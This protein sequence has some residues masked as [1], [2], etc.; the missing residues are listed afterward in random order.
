MREY[1]YCPF[2]RTPMK[3]NAEGILACQD[4]QECGFV[5]YDNPIPVVAV[6][7]PMAHEFLA[8]AGMAVQ[9]IPDKGIVL[10]RRKNPPYVG[11]WCLPCGYM[12]QYGNPKAEAAREALEETG[13]I[14]RAEKILCV[15]NPVPGAVN[16]LTISYLARPVG[17]IL[18][19]G[20]D[21]SQVGVF[22]EVDLPDVCF[23]SHRMVLDRW[24]AG[25]FGALTG[26]DLEY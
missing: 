3:R 4:A 12:N 22:A 2:C 15:C 10:V 17:G 19:A 11:E 16:Q 8:Q 9:D 21:A 14:V 6:L 24:L 13:L 26:Q 25:E 5:H 7:I 18:Q 20:D 23:R 1:R